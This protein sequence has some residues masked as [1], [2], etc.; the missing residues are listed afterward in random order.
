MMKRSV[1]FFSHDYDLDT[2]IEYVNTG[3][4]S[5]LNCSFTSE[6][7]DYGTDTI[8]SNLSSPPKPREQ[9][10]YEMAQEIAAYLDATEDGVYRKN[11]VP[12]EKQY[13]DF[14]NSTLYAIEKALK[15]LAG[16]Y[17]PIQ[18]KWF[19][20]I[21]NAGKMIAE[22]FLSGETKCFSYCESN[23]DEMNENTP[24]KYRG[25]GWYGIKRIPGFFDNSKDEFIIA[26]G[27][28]GGGNCAF[29]YV[30]WGDTD[31]DEPAIAVAN[32]ICESTGRTLDDIIFVEIEEDDK[33][34]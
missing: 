2:A 21:R 12:Y 29:G 4:Y 23:Q 30:Y 3:M 34:E 26:T 16:D 5:M 8:H 17:N 9:M 19:M 7:P 27:Y 13:G 25:E 22:K 33:D 32:A 20:T 28:Y 15:D 6:D 31:T 10:A 18:T 14:S 24:D 11:G 1:K